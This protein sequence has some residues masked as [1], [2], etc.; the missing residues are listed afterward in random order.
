[1]IAEAIAPALFL[2]AS[3][4]PVLA[5][6]TAAPALLP[7]AP[8]LT[9]HHTALLRQ[10]SPRLPLVLYVAQ[11]ANEAQAPQNSK[12][13]AC[14]LQCQPPPLEALPSCHQIVGFIR[15]KVSLPF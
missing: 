14:R 4:S 11:A 6:S 2:C 1:M 12:H 10:Q 3:G 15:V 5:H 13:K 8:P 7:T 9:T